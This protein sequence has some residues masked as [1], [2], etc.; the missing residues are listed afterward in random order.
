M[1]Y[2]LLNDYLNPILKQRISLGYF[3]MSTPIRILFALFFFGLSFPILAQNFYTERISR[4]NIFSIG[5]GP[6]FAYM[7]NG[8]QYR[9][10]NFEIK[11]SISASL[12]KRLNPRFDL[13]STAGVQW[14]SSGGNPA[15]VVK[16]IWVAN[17]SSF[18]SEGQGVYFDIMPSLNIVPFSN[19]M[20]RSRWNIYGGLGIGV[21]HVSSQQTKNFNEN[22]VAIKEQITTAYVPVRAGLSYRIGPYSDIAGEGTMFLTFSDNLDGNVGFNRFG[23][24]LAQAQIVYRKYFTRKSKD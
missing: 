13:R 8:G 7:D 23:D 1:A 24:H 21:M 4:N 9:A 16:D 5:M 20:H 11:P 22:E 15:P 3:E 6:S 19:H 18:T 12:I 14:I 10:G 17:A 2:L